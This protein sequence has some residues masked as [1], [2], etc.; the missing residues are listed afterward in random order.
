MIFKTIEDDLGKTKFAINNTLKGLFNGNLFKSEKLLSDGDIKALQAY[1]AEIERGVSPMTA[2]YRTMQNASDTAVNMAKSAGEG[3]VQ[4]NNMTKASKA[5][6]IGMQALATV[7]NMF[8]GMAI[9][10]GIGKIVEGIDNYIHR[11]EKAIEKAQEAQQAI[12]DA[13]SSFKNISNTLDENKDRFLELSQGVSKF[14]KNL[15]LSEDDYKEYLSISNE[16]AELFPTLVYGYDEQGNALLNIGDSADETNKK[17]QELL[18]TEEFLAQKT[19]IDNMDDV[20][21]GVYYEVK[22]SKD[23]LGKLQ[24]DLIAAQAVHDQV[25]VVSL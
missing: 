9:S 12:D 19:L 5:A 25:S 23:T 22:D 7:G 6:K 1:N 15:S 20:A 24:A 21:N 16:L 17:L 4:I 14:S 8:L 11:A 2:Y 3:T 10:W 18:E 13:Q